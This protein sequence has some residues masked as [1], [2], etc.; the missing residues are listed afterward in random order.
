MMRV[1]SFDRFVHAGRII[2]A[3]ALGGA[4]LSGL[5]VGLLPA[6]AAV[7][8]HAVGAVIGGVA[9]AVANARHLV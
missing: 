9:G 1:S 3:F 8:V 4:V 6:L 7:D 5:T 2:T